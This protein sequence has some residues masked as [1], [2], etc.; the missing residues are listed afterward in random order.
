MSRMSCLRTSIICRVVIIVIIATRLSA[1]QNQQSQTPT[2]HY[3]WA[4]CGVTVIESSPARLTLD[5]TPCWKGFD[6]VILHGILY[7]SPKIVGTQISAHHNSTPPHAELCI[8]VTVPSSQGFIVSSVVVRNVRSVSARML[9]RVEGMYSRIAIDTAAHTPSTE[10]PQWYSMH[11]AGIGRDRHIAILKLRAARFNPSSTSIELP[12]SIRIAIEFAPED[13]V[14][15]TSHSA[16][17]TPPFEIPELTLATTINHAQTSLW[18]INA[19]P[20][21]QLADISLSLSASSSIKAASQQ[22]VT[23]RWARIGVERDGIYRITAQQL[24]DIGITIANNEITSIRLFGN[25]GVELPES[26]ALST[27][28]TMQ[29][30]PLIIETDAQGAFAALMFFGCAPHGFIARYSDSTQPPTIQHFL[31][32][33]SRRTFYMLTVGGNVQGQR[34]TFTEITTAATVFP[35]YHI[36][37]VFKEDDLENPFDIGLSGSGRRWLGQRFSNNRAVRFETPLPHLVRSAVPILYRV[38]A[39]WN[40]PSGAA[41][42]GKIFVRESGT[43]VFSTPFTFFG[44]TSEYLVGNIETRTATLPASVIA[45]NRSVLEFVYMADIGDGAHGILDW[46]EIH[47]PREFIASDNQLDFFTDTPANQSGIAEYTVRGFSSSP[48]FIVDA[49]HRAR[50][51]FIR[52]TSVVSGQ[53]TFRAVI[54]PRAPRRFFLSSQ[55]LSVPSLE[56]I[57]DILDLRNTPANADV[58]VITHKDLLASA[59]AYREYRERQSNMTVA[60]VTTDQIYY[61]FNGGTPDQTAL[62][63][64]I[65]HAFRTWQ[66]KPRYVLLWGDTH[67]DIRGIIPNVTARNFVPTYQFYD[68]DGDLHAISTNYTTEDY[69]VCVNGDDNIV[70]LAIG[71]LCVRSN[72]EGMT[73]LSKIRRYETASSLDNWRTHVLLTADDAPTKDLATS[74]GTLHTGQS[75]DLAQFIIPSDIRVRK[76]YLPDFPTENTP[77]G[78]RRPGATQD[79]IAAINEGVLILNWIGHGNPRVWANEEFLQRDVTIPQFTNLDRLFFLV[80]ATCDFARFDNYRQQSGAEEMLSSPRGG[81]IAVFAASRTVYSGDNAA[82]SQ[83]LYR[84]IFRNTGSSEPPRF[85]DLVFA[86]KQTFYTGFDNNDRKFCLLGDP[87]VRLALPQQPVIIDSINGQSTSILAPLPTV[88]ALSRMTVSGSVM[89]PGSTIIDTALNGTILA[90]LH[91]TDVQRLVP[92]VDL[93]RTVHRITSLGGLLNIGA[94]SVRQGRFRLSLPIPQDISFSNQPGRLFFYVVSNDGRKFGRGA[95]SHFILGD[96]DETAINDGIGPEIRLFM[97]TRSFKPGDFVSST[98]LLIADMY[99][100]TGIN[101]TGIGIGHDIQCWIDDNPIPI[102]LT[103]NYRVSLED[104]RRGTVERRLPALLPGIHRVRVRAW[105]IFNNY[106]E[107]ETYFRVV[108]SDSMLVVTELISYPNPFAEQTT[109]RFRHNQQSEQPYTVAIYSAN[110]TP[111]TTFSGVTTARTIEILWNGRD[112]SGSPVPSGAYMILVHVT[113]AHRQTQSVSGYVLRSR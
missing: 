1:A 21:Q 71:R 86:V 61:Q 60:V 19:I 88:K 14:H 113:G 106:S 98:P 50:P 66:R 37:R 30:Q 11:Y 70:D 94:S 110:G 35:S 87:T 89:L 23:G 38:C 90:S 52:N 97:D 68:P 101:A 13:A 36:A 99:D 67:F 75:E 29:E 20:K 64:Y 69:F 17:S 26:V 65:A 33:F 7:L 63:D 47:Y 32:T 53:A 3:G 62:R 42:G 4:W 40:N 28:N 15:N 6:T 80:A 54:S 108:S 48:I 16:L 12:Q 59:Q 45:N 25:G 18:R 51:Q 95:T 74:D 77:G 83:E 24:R 8:P 27:T 91:D 107:N 44:S 111:V 57:D 56:R 109:I 73:I 104:P 96:L 92:D 93:N 76:T 85:G 103:R 100:D 49:T 84:Q 112:A 72:D 55:T 2:V 81:A 79:M 9:S 102:I 46:F 5:Y 39:A 43:E 22:S 58:I 78:R 41:P 82:I 105:D 31:N 34:A 10:P